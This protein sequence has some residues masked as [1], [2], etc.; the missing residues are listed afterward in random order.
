MRPNGSWLVVKESNEVMRPN[1]S[2]LV[3]KEINE[4]RV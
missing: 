3:V 1:G 4:V 2:W